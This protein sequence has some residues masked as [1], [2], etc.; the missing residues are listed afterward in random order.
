[1]PRSKGETR[2]ARKRSKEVSSYTAPD[3][4]IK[5]LESVTGLLAYIRTH[6]GGVPELLE[7]SGWD[8][9]RSRYAVSLLNGLKSD[10]SRTAK[11]F[12][13]HVNNC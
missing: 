12:G 2:M 5:W 8:A 4:I 1:M 9:S 7:D 11:E 3:E 13:S 6:Y 10:L